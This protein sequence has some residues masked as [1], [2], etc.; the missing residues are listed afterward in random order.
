MSKGGVVPAAILERLRAICLPL[1]GAYEEP[2]W[3]GTR[4]MVRGRNFAH[5][6]A[7]V[8]GH[9]PAYARAAGTGGPAVVLTFRV[10]DVAAD[11]FRDAGPRR[12]LAVWGTRWRTKVAGLVLGA[13]VA[14]REVEPLLVDSH[15][16]LAPS[17]KTRRLP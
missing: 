9:P 11:A 13:R 5:V 7:I 1:P 15:R 10:P 8:D 17:S 16:L 12:F 4:W 14:W 2:A 6:L 3:V